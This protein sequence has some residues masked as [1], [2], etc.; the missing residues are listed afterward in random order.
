MRGFYSCDSNQQ[1]LLSKKTKSKSMKK[2]K[3][4]EQIDVKNVSI[5][6][7]EIPVVEINKGRIILSK[8]SLKFIE[9]LKTKQINASTSDDI[10]KILELLVQNFS[11]ISEKEIASANITATSPRIDVLKVIERILKEIKEDPQDKRDFFMKIFRSDDFH[12][13]CTPD[14]CVEIFVSAL[15]GSSDITLKLFEEVMSNYSVDWDEVVPDIP[16]FIEELQKLQAKKESQKSDSSAKKTKKKAKTPSK[17]LERLDQ[18]SKLLNLIARMLDTLEAEKVNVPERYIKLFNEINAK[19]PIPEET[20][21]ISLP[22][23]EYSKNMESLNEILGK[24]KKIFEF[25]AIT[26]PADA[27]NNWSEDRF[28]RDDDEEVK[29]KEPEPKN[30]S[31]K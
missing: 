30:P 24:L 7:K 9:T 11:S 17:P 27:K 4:S 16:A 19:Y 25:K 29:T 14:D 15:T 12:E 21:K 26:L 6:A 31:P 5:S 20:K 2:K 10:S 3:E 13:I 18:L 28:G 8:E 1:I 23:S 22:E